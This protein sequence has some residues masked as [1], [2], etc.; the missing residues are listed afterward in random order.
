MQ[1]MHLRVSGLTGVCGL[2]AYAP[3]L[4]RL[5]I[6]ASIIQ[7]MHLR[8]CGLIARSTHLTPPPSLKRLDV[9]YAIIPN[10]V[11]GVER[12]GEEMVCWAILQNH[13]RSIYTNLRSNISIGYHFAKYFNKVF[14]R[15]QLNYTH[16]HTTS[17]VHV[18]TDK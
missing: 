10:T 17:P 8:A 3:T 5:R 13:L 14:D 7:T 12:R 18:R 9:P 4:T 15:L 16:T 6:H 1:P 2:T 11:H